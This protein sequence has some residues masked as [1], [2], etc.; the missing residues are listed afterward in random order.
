MC[1]TPP[2]SPRADISRGK[3]RYHLARGVG[4]FVDASS[5]N[6]RSPSKALGREEEGKLKHVS[7]EAG[8]G[9]LLLRHAWHSN[10]AIVMQV[11]LNHA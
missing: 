9:P 2:A 10:L 5:L 7:D 4:I 8:H 6:R 1:C 3:E 11:R